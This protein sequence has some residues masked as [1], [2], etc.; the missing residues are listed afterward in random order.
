MRCMASPGRSRTSRECIALRGNQ[1]P[2]YP[3]VF[4]Q[5]K[6][7]DQRIAM[8]QPPCSL[9][10]TRPGSRQAGHQA[11]HTCLR[12]CLATDVS[13]VTINGVAASGSLPSD[14]VSG[15]SATFPCE[16]YLA[17]HTGEARRGAACGRR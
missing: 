2:G 15:A 14:L 1:G 9:A 3:A 12:R 6:L 17:E 7:H 11:T 5:E 8:A 13:D 4:G 16:T 10:R